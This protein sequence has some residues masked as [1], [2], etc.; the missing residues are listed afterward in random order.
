MKNAVEL[1]TPDVEMAEEKSTTRKKKGAAAPEE[2]K[3]SKSASKL[4]VMPSLKNQAKKTASKNS[5][6]FVTFD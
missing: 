6:N 4:E 1:A 2:S 5:I 3:T